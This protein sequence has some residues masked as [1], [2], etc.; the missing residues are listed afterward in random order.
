[1]YPHHF[2]NLEKFHF[3]NR[4]TRTG[5]LVEI[6]LLRLPRGT[7]FSHRADEDYNP[8]RFIFMVENESEAMYMGTVTH[9][10]VL[11]RGLRGGAF[12]QARDL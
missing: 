10:G 5:G 11:Q 12:I 9:A 2:S 4:R 7:P 3:P 1:M 8:D 6:P